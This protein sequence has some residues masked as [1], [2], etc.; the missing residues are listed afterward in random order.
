MSGFRCPCLAVITQEKTL[1]AAYEEH[2]EEAHLLEKVSTALQYRFK[3][4]QITRHLKKLGL[5]VP[6]RRR[7]G[8][9]V[10]NAPHDEGF[11]AGDVIML[12]ANT[13]VKLT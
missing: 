9:Q 3:R 8:S 11:D 13:F 7:A 1:R 5:P 4:S 12:F 6:K 2:K 10:T